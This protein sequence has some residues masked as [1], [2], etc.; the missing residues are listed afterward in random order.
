MLD[1]RGWRSSKG[2]SEYGVGRLGGQGQCVTLGQLPAWRGMETAVAAPVDY[3]KLQ[4]QHG[5]QMGCNGGLLRGAA[6]NGEKGR[7]QEGWDGAEVACGREAGGL[8]QGGVGG[9][10]SKFY[11]TQSY[12]KHMRS[13]PLC[14][15]CPA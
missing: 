8:A 14:D 3:R 5:L 10:G 7:W 1:F 13:S 2:A 15:T 11:K 12:I 9:G 6:R 4:L